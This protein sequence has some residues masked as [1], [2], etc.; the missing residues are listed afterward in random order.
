[1]QIIQRVVRLIAVSGFLL[2]NGS[3]WASEKLVMTGSSTIAPLA[4]EIA[5]RFEKLNP[6]VRIDVQSGGSSRGVSDARSGL[7]DIGMASRALKAEEKDLTGHTI[8]L[9]GIGIILHKNNPV[10]SLTDA[11]IKAVYTGQIT[12]WKALG[13]KDE[14]ITVVNKAE[15]RST[16]ELFLHYFALKNS[17]IKAQVVIGDN[18]QGIKTVAGNPGSIGY[19]SIG[20][21]EF[22]EAQGTPVKLLPMEGI[23]A[24]VANIRNSSFPLSRPLN[25]VTKGTP[26]DLAKR[27]IEFARSAKNNDLVEA[28]FFV[29]IAR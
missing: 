25:L 5:K 8:A 1:M 20:T 14:S 19:V 29:P 6:G 17:D 2:V 12:N 11:Q 7:A 26:S 13:G 4:L 16:L 15:G 18:Q 27:F 3:S 10:K 22:E 28:Q 21:A 24:T 23:S 9:D